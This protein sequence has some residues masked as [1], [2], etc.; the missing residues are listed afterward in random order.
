[1]KRLLQLLIAITLTIGSALAF[2]PDAEAQIRCDGLMS[3]YDA[4]LAFNTLP[5]H[6][7]GILDIEKTSS[8]V[9]FHQLRQATSLLATLNAD[10]IF[11]L[12][13]APEVVWVLKLEFRRA[14]RFWETR[15]KRNLSLEEV[16]R[17]TEGPVHFTWIDKHYD[18][19][20]VFT[21]EAVEGTELQTLHALNEIKVVDGR[22]FAGGNVVLNPNSAKKYLDE[23][24]TERLPL[25]AH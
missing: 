20:E 7:K 13:R 15:F 16:M 17:M 8:F 25:D 5:T 21:V 14:P 23:K 2:A 1:M 4:G 22:V 9:R 10:R 11:V 12:R 3:G 24:A 19:F 6:N 18:R